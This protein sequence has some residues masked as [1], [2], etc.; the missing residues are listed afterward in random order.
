MGDGFLN[1]NAPKQLD[2]L[3]DLSRIGK[4]EEEYEE[5]ERTVDYLRKKVL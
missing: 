2:E 4:T 1:K 3:V 5:E